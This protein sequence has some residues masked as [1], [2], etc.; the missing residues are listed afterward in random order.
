[1]HISNLLCAS[2]ACIRALC[3]LPSAFITPT[4]LF[5][6]S[7]PISQIGRKSINIFC[8][9]YPQFLTTSGNVSSI[10]GTSCFFHGS[11]TCDFSLLCCTSLHQ[12]GALPCFYYLK[13]TADFGIMFCNKVP[14]CHIHIMCSIQLSKLIESKENGQ[15]INFT[16][17]L[18]HGLRYDRPHLVWLSR[19]CVKHEL[20]IG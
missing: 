13:L 9:R 19:V 15:K 16:L 3:L 14:W 7:S 10:S 17:L 6:S 20:D 18:M 1:M 5:L 2:Y 4:H 12:S 8:G 11:F